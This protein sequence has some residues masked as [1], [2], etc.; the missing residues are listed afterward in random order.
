MCMAL[1]RHKPSLIPLLFSAASTCGVMLMY[2]RRVFVSNVSSSRCDFILRALA[3]SKSHID[4]GAHRTR[5]TGSQQNGG[6]CDL[7]RAVGNILAGDEHFEIA[8]EGA[9]AVSVHRE[10][11]FERKG[12]ENVVV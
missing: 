5:H 4:S 3:H 7:N 8:A 10:I 12:V 11:T 1:T 2:A 6:A 9:R